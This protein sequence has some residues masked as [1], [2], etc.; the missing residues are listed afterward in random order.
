MQHQ[1][2]KKMNTTVLEILSENEMQQ[3]KGGGYWVWIN[4]QWRWISE[5]SLDGK[6]EDTPPPPPP[7]I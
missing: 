2:Q 3:I 4:E 6:D 7:S 5:R 1:K